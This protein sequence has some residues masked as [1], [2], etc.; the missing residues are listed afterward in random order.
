VI[1]LS[2]REAPEQVIWTAISAVPAPRSH[3]FDRNERVPGPGFMSP[4]VSSTTYQT[5]GTRILLNPRPSAG[6]GSKLTGISLQK[7]SQTQGL[8][9]IRVC[10]ETLSAL[11]AVR[12]GQ[13]DNA[14]H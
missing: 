14:R 4:H 6:A 3:P 12:L 9:Y 10:E 8:E 13:N 1:Q 5:Y 2:S 7:N 11:S